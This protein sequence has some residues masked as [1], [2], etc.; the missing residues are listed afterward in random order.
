MVI[1]IF[2]E[3]KIFDILINRQVVRDLCLVFSFVAS[4]STFCASIKCDGILQVR[5]GVNVE[6]GQPY[7]AETTDELYCPFICGVVNPQ[8]R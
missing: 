2:M 3:S 6:F 1:L 5:L 4:H 8:S 7:Q